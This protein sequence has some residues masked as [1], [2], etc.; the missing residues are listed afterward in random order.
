MAP[1][2]NMADAAGGST[3]LV[4]RG[5]RKIARGLAGG[6]IAEPDYA[7]ASV[8]ALVAQAWRV[9][10]RCDTRGIQ[11]WQSPLERQILYALARAMPGPIAELGAWL[12]LSTC[13]ICAGIR[14]S[15]EAKEFVTHEINPK[16]HWFR[17]HG[18]RIGFFPPGS[19]EPLAHCTYE[20]YHQDIRPAVEAPGGVI[21]ELRRNLA[22]RGFAGMVR[23]I[24]GDF[25]AA[26]PRV[27]SFIFADVMHNE[28]EIRESGP[29]LR[30]M[31]A[32]GTV[33]ACHDCNP[34]FEA[35]LRQYLPFRTVGLL[36][37][38]LVAVVGD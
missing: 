27:Y 35:L 29:K 8:D 20:T 38:M 4:R 33:L 16:S 30:Y 14:D 21:G 37:S 31:T 28:A 1:V 23:V 36:D 19:T 32:P 26:N 22:A 9:R 3:G 18:D 17:P 12:G 6:L 24:E 25:G 15:G 10:V 34:A 7:H 5:A 11:G 2:G 13:I